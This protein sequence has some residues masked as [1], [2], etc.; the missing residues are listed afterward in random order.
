MPLSK[1]PHDYLRR[2]SPESYRGLAMVHWTLTVADRRTGWLDARA[3]A[4]WREALLHTL[5]RYA[6]AAP[7]YCLMP[8]HVHVLLVGMAERSD[9]QRALSFLRRYSAR[10]FVPDGSENADEKENPD[11]SGS[12]SA[13]GQH[14]GWQKQA[15]DHVLREEERRGDA[16]KAVA[17]YIVENPVRAGLVNTADAWRF[18]GAVVAGWPALDW[19]QSDFWDRWWR[20]F[21]TG[22]DEN[23]RGTED[24]DGS[25]SASAT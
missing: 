16:F 14:P 6:L 3:H 13:T 1:P 9:Q 8:D 11:G 5:A 21:A 24:S 12:A 22:D 4:C 25:G 2:L 20:I 7:V 15:Y 23:A 17:H 18:S 19:R 10:M